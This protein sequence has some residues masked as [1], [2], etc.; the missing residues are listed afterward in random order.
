MLREIESQQ[1]FAPF[2]RASG[3]GQSQ[4]EKEEQTPLR[5]NLVITPDLLNT[6]NHTPEAKEKQRKWAENAHA[7]T[8]T[9]TIRRGCSD[10]RP[11]LDSPTQE[12]QQSSISA[13]GPQSDYQGLINAPYVREVVNEGHVDLRK[14]RRGQEPLDCGG[15]KGRL[16]LER[17]GVVYREGDPNSEDLTAYLLEN[18]RHHDAALNTLNRS[19]RTAALTDK[20]VLAAVR[21]H[22]TQ[23]LIPVGIFQTQGGVARTFIPE[24]FEAYHRGK[25]RYDPEEIY[26]EGIPSLPED[27]VN[28]YFGDLLERNRINVAALEAKYN[29]RL[30]DI[31]EVQKPDAVVVTT[32]KRPTAS[33]FDG[34]L[35]EHGRSFKISVPRATTLDVDDEKRVVITREMMRPMLRQIDFPLNNAVAHRNQP[36]KPFSNTQTIFIATQGMDTSMYIARAIMGKPLMEPWVEGGGQVIISKIRHGEIVDIDQL[37]RPRAH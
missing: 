11:E 35:D 18:V 24:G 25:R 36:E 12:I 3:D 8:P 30:P 29:G 17:A 20:P 10:S 32:L 9:M 15:G 2:D 4:D 21:D 5:E 37:I 14:F 13:S 22:G 33:L 31:L 34:T 26:A 19:E 28:E 16:Q 6:S 27:L 1:F 7:P 23:L